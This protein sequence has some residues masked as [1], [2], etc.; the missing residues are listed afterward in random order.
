MLKTSKGNPVYLKEGNFNK[1]FVIKNS[2]MLWDSQLFELIKAAIDTGLIFEDKEYCK[3]MMFEENICV[4]MEK[5][6][7]CYKVEVFRKEE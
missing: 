2:L 6:D 7:E 4:R 5:A 1:I 3:E